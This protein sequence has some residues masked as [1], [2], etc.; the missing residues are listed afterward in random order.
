MVKWSCASPLCFNNFRT[1]SDKGEGI[2][3]YRLPRDKSIIE[4]YKRILRTNVLNV[5]YGYICAE[6]WSK[7][8]RTDT[9]DL[10]DVPVPKSQVNVITKKYNLAKERFRQLKIPKFSDKK[11]LNNI[12]EKYQLA[13]RLTSE[14][15][16]S[17]SISTPCSKH[18]APK[19]RVLSSPLK[20][21][22]SLSKNELVRKLNNSN[23][24]HDD[25]KDQL[26]KAN[27]KN[28]KLQ[29][30]NKSLKV[31][32][33]YQKMKIKSDSKRISE[34]QKSLDILRS[35]KFTYENLIKKPNLFQFITGLP[36]D[37]FNLLLE[38]ILPYAHII[39]YPNCKGTGQRALDKATELVC[40][41]TI[42]RHSLS[43]GVMAYILQVEKPTVYR[44]FTGWVVF[45]ETLIEE[46]DLNPK[47][48]FLIK[49]MPDIFMKTGHG[50][51]DM[52]IDCTEFKFQH[53]TNY[54]LNSLMFS[55]YKNTVTGKALIGITAH[56]SGLLFSGIYPGSIGDTQIT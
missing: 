2:N 21:K 52:V 33:D 48:G 23:E 15:F 20:R 9:K 17:T 11:C 47:N 5:E 42:C 3:K 26:K 12:K 4:A 50:L 54:E 8:Y 24:Q 43:Y 27:E 40:F 41:V 19:L 6:H 28:N 18:K 25:L 53:A 37:K 16:P 31:K 51:T 14:N 35:K 7:G 10:P 55:N 38:T 34:M 30:E 56:G 22:R 49:K 1:R 29:Q 46:I 13:I 39:K 44:I 36:I 32:L 45:L